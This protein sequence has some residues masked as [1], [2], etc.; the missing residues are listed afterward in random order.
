M[1]GGSYSIL[2][3]IQVSLLSRCGNFHK[4]SAV[5]LYVPLGSFEMTGLY[6]EAYSI[7]LVIALCL[8]QM[9]APNAVS[10][11]QAFVDNGIDT[12]LTVGPIESTI[13]LWI[14]MHTLEQTMKHGR[15]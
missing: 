6:D 2:V 5:R 9:Y 14:S 15:T 4:S 13:L 3:L 7:G 10:E 12:L 8:L 1:V 11:Y